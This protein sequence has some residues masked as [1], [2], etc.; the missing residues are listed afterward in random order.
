MVNSFR[1]PWSTKSIIKNIPT[2]MLTFF[3]MYRNSFAEPLGYG[4]VSKPIPKILAVVMDKHKTKT[5][6]HTNKHTYTH[7]A[8]YFLFLSNESTHKAL[9]FSSA[10]VEDTCPK[11][12]AV[13]LNLRPH[14]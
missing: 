11:C 7:K 10:I 2:V 4:D 9:F 6:I 1:Q 14:G 12:H 8:G 3:N 5:N 13:G